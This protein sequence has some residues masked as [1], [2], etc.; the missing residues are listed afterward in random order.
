MSPRRVNFV[1]FLRSKNLLLTRQWLFIIFCVTVKLAT[2]A[3]ALKGA[4][5]RSELNR[6]LLTHFF[7]GAH[8][9][10]KYRS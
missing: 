1:S 6:K 7:K 2:V 4:S 9:S 3:Y 8:V 10:S 5:F